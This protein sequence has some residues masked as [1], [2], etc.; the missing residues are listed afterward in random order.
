MDVE[1]NMKAA[2]WVRVSTTEQETENQLSNLKA[3]AAAKDLEVVETYSINE[4]AYRGTQR[5]ALEAMYRD[6]HQGRFQVLLVWSLDRL[7]REGIRQ[8]LE[9]FNQLSG[10]GV[11]VPSYQEPWTAS[12][13]PEIRELMISI[14][15]WIANQY[16]RRLSE[17]TKAGMA[18]A[19]ANGKRLGR[20]PGAKDKKQRRRR[21]HFS[22]N[23]D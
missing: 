4:S 2:I 1:Y 3:W 12:A 16:S 15:G 8:T 23:A 7:S 18:R 20:P 5:N 11:R 19:K 21:R 10:H 13:G 9:I 6:A 22:R 17:N 14:T